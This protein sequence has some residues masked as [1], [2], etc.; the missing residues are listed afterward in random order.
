MDVEVVRGPSAIYL[1]NKANR[2][3]NR[4]QALR[5]M[6]PEKY[7][8]VMDYVDDLRAEARGWN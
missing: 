1:L 7:V 8:H 3:H 5:L 2:I 4:A 6:D